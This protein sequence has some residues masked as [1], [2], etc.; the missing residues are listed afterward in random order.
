MAQTPFTAA[1]GVQTYSGRVW[2]ESGITMTVNPGT[3]SVQV[4]VLHDKAGSEWIT[5]GGSYTSTQA[6]RLLPPHGT[7]FRVTATGNAT[8]NVHGI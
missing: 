3:G 8:F 5:D 1:D 6:Y 2:P 4:E 7:A